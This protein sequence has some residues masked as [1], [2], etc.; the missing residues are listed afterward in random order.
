MSADTRSN[1][2]LARMM[3]AFG[4]LT[5]LPV[6]RRAAYDPV[7]MVPFFPLVGL[8]IGVL[9]AGVDALANQVFPPAVAAAL[10]LMVLAVIT[11]A[12]HLDGLAD[13]ADGLFAHHA[14]ER[15]LVIMKDSRVGAMGVVALVVCLMVKY[16]GCRA[17]GDSRWAALMAAPALARASAVVAMIRLNYIRPGGGTGAPFFSRPLEWTAW[18][19]MAP[20]V[21]APLFLGFGALAMLVVFLLGTGSILFFYRRR[22]GGVTG[23]MLG[24]L[25]ETME[26]VLLITA[27]AGSAI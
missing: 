4:F 11:G 19:G 17:L 20:A 22:M 6:G 8:G 7:G 26:T 15:A 12:F 9:T 5:I 3:G 2:F 16:S 18:A 10:D 24:A 14:P 25:I 21:A 23:D 1:S 27:A 13:T